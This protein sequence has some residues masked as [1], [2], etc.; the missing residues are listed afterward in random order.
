M[1]Q[2]K[3]KNPPDEKPQPESDSARQA[4]A[5]GR[6]DNNAF[7]VIN[8]MHRLMN[9]GV[10]MP[11]LKY[12]LAA[13]AMICNKLGILNGQAG[14]SNPAGNS[15]LKKCNPKYRK[16]EAPKG[17]PTQMLSY[18]LNTL[19]S[20]AE[21]SQAP[22][23]YGDS[24]LFTGYKNYNYDTPVTTKFSAYRK[25]TGPPTAPH[26][27]NSHVITNY[28]AYG[29]DSQD[30]FTLELGWEGIRTEKRE[31]FDDLIAPAKGRALAGAVP[32]DEDQ[33]SRQ[34]LAWGNHVATGKYD[35]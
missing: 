15:T 22:P 18:D 9:M 30:G 29:G 1:N 33:L 7:E 19:Q 11:Q 5:E 21:I 14:S 8:R 23:N 32:Y 3:V 10:F 12:R 2:Q 27:E 4:Y 26:R 31:F 17:P 20:Q 28:V 25:E 34:V 35:V 24:A 6:I 16:S 13:T